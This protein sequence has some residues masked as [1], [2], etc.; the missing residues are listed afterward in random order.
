MLAPEADCMDRDDPP[1][2]CMRLSPVQNPGIVLHCG[3]AD[4]LSLETDARVTRGH[5]QVRLSMI[6][7]TMQ[8]DVQDFAAEPHRPCVIHPSCALPVTRYP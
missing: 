3:Y 7:I 2:G 5:T 8:V 4:D 1:G 6:F